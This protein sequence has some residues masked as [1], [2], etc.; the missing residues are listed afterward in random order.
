MAGRVNG[1]PANPDKVPPQRRM[2]NDEDTP[3][4]NPPERP[5]NEPPTDFPEEGE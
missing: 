2:G 1:T 5:K 3:L 4:S